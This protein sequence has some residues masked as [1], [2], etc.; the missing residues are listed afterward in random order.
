MTAYINGLAC[1]SH[2]NTFDENYFF[3]DVKTLPVSNKL[4]AT[5][6]AYKE[7][8]PAALIRRM[9]HIVK[10]GVAAGT[11]SLK[12]A[13]LEKVDA[14]IVGTGIGCFDDTDK[15]LRSMLDN[16]EQLLTPTSFIQS[17]HNTV[18]GQLALLLKCYGYNF[19]YVHQNL[20]FEY[21]L[22]DAMMQ[23]EE[24]E[25]E[26]ILVGGID[27]VTDSIFE[28]FNRAGHL[29][30]LSDNTSKSIVAKGYNIGEGA[31]FFTIA[32]R[33][34]EQTFA[35]LS[36]VKCLQ[37]IANSLDLINQTE[38]FLKECL[39]QRNDISLVLSG[40]CGDAEM[41]KT[42]SEF[43]VLM[44][45]PVGQFKRLCGEYFTASGF[46]VWL[47]ANIFKKQTVPAI[48]LESNT[49]VSN[50]QHILIVNHYHNQQYSLMCVSIC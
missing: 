20:S 8:I 16:N 10:M 36:G 33:K 2:H 9:S 21:A 47:A 24:K 19:T 42:I 28:L 50:I 3:E 7:Y 1:I 11:S 40:N 29:R 25:A 34:N 31:S 38:T 45:I 17:T 23:L 22:L 14:I 43:N 48:L 13:A 44:N 4:S 35:K 39:L 32:A 5:E 46:A 30:Q 41:D 12:K 15:F 6:P 49:R 37:Q 18:A 27:E 26:S